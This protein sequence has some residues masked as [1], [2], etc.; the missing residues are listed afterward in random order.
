MYYE[1]IGLCPRSDM[2]MGSWGFGINLWPQF[3]EAVAKSG[4][5]AEHA[6][7]AI[8]THGRQW[9]DGCGYEVMYDPDDNRSVYERQDE[10]REMGPNARPLY[11]VCQLRLQWGEWGPEHISVPG[12]ACGLDIGHGLGT[13][14]DGMHLSPHNIDCMKQAMLLI[15]IFT[16]FAESITI[17]CRGREMKEKKDD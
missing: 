11:D 7:S 3:R 15:V 4:I 6:R 13:P 8:Q 5:T 2:S 10:P 9:L 17:Q 14:R 12:N 1:I 16:W